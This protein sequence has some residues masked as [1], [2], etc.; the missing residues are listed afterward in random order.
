MISF[1]CGRFSDAQ[2]SSAPGREFR[3]LLHQPF[4]LPG[5]P[6]APGV[7]GPAG[8]DDHIRIFRCAVLRVLKGNE[9]DIHRQAGKRLVEMD[10]GMHVRLMEMPAQRPAA[11]GSPGMH[12]RDADGQRIRLSVP[13]Q[14]LDP[15]EFIRDGVDG[16]TVPVGDVDGMAA[17]ISACLDQPALLQEMGRNIRSRAGAFGVDDIMDQWDRLFRNRVTG[18]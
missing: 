9:P 12:D 17:R 7:P 14:R 13:V 15:A 16:Y 6:A 8:V 1:G 2:K 10:Q 3:Q 4:A 11:Q 18:R 5:V